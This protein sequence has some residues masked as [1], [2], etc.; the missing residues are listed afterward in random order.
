MT[1]INIPEYKLPLVSPPS[2]PKYAPTKP[3]K[4]LI[5]VSMFAYLMKV[6]GK[7]YA[8]YVPVGLYGIIGIITFLPVNVFYRNEREMFKSCLYRTVFGGLNSP[9]PFTDILFADVLTSFSR[10]LGDFQIV[11]V[12]L[13]SH[14]NISSIAEMMNIDPHKTIPRFSKRGLDVEFPEPNMLSFG[15]CVLYFVICLPFIFRLRQC[16][17]EWHQCHDDVIGTRH[18]ANALKY[19]SALPVILS[20]FCI[21]YFRI[22]YHGKE[23]SQEMN[24][25]LQMKLNIAIIFWIITS[26]IN[27]LFS[28][29]WDIRMDWNLG[30]IPR[31]PQITAKKYPIK[32][33]FPIFLRPVLHFQHVILYYLAI[34]LDIILRLAWIPKVALLYELVEITVRSRSNNKSHV[35]VPNG[36]VELPKLLVAD[37]TLKV[38]E[39]FRRWVWVFFRIEREWVVCGLDGNFDSNGRRNRK[40]VNMRSPLMTRRTEFGGSLGLNLEK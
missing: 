21:Q 19:L 14:S 9:V 6:Y 40:V 16:L 30:N 3:T 11:V 13:V 34:I 29:F 35:I 8:N 5:G 33:D 10:V 36:E 24:D 38:L 28:I 37:L 26:T 15:D 27:S 17:A 39:I 1:S 23:L 18:F 2:L 7:D 12:D 4:G 22:I 25:A 20:L 32:S 31:P